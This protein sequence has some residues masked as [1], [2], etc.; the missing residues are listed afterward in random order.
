MVH[1]NFFMEVQ[2]VS[3]LAAGSRHENQTGGHILFLLTHD[4]A[5]RPLTRW[6]NAAREAFDEFHRLGDE[7]LVCCVELIKCI[8]LQPV[9]QI[10]EPL[11]AKAA[12]VV[13]GH[14][15]QQAVV[16]PGT[17]RS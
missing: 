7:V 1:E 2:G 17:S 11:F 15:P 16:A 9:N 5:F 10:L 14:V 13:P 6:R 3:L 8:S 4:L 12:D